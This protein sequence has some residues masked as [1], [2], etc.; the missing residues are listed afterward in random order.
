MTSINFNQKNIR[1]IPIRRNSLFYDMQSFSFE[2]ELG[3]NYVEQDMGQTA[4]LYQVDAAKSQI[5]AT[6]GESQPNSIVYKLPIEIPCVYNIDKGELKS[7]DKEKSLAT[8]VKTGKLTL[9]VYQA[10]LDELHADIKK[11]DYIGIM[12]DESHQEYFVVNNDGK[13]N[14]DNSH[15]M[16]GIKP[17]YRTI[18]ASSV[19]PS[20]FRNNM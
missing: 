2:Q 18:I 14:Y 3:K 1:R 9:G 17:F 15:T 6:Y 16:F 7:Y 12:I 11:G 8:Y 13:N 10:T 4:I 5:H 19:D 20:E